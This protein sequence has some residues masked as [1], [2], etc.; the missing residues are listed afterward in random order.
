MVQPYITKR[1]IRIKVEVFFAIKTLYTVVNVYVE[2]TLLKTL[3][4][5]SKIKN[6]HTNITK[7]YFLEYTARNSKT[8][9]CLTEKVREKKRVEGE[10]TKSE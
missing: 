8:R 1:L 2:I 3:L 4:L 7:L 10:E 5:K 9:I 6:K